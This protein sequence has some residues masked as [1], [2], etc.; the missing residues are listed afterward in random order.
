M[1]I[2]SVA[3]GYVVKTPIELD[4]GTIRIEEYV[5]Q[6]DEI[7]DPLKHH[8][9]LLWHVMEYFAFGGCKHDE[10]RIRIY[11]ET[12]DGKILDGTEDLPEL[13]EQQT[14]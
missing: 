7:K 12:R 5:I 9:E 6:E 11:R 10:Q 14:S 2:H 3:N 8:E 13:T 1:E 4:D